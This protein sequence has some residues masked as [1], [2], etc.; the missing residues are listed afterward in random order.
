MLQFGMVI[1]NRSLVN[2]K[3]VVMNTHA[4]SSSNI[5]I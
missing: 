2:D 3:G 4:S 1:R 5:K